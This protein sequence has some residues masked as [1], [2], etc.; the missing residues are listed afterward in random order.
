MR[1]YLFKTHKHKSPRATLK[2]LANLLSFAVGVAAGYYTEPALY[3]SRLDPAKER[4][5]GEVG[6]T[7]LKLR[8]YPG[9]F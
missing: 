3:H 6:V 2:K 1:L 9:A 7:G 5:F 4:H 8:I